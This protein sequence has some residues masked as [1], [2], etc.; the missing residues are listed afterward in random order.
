[1]FAAFE[2]D[3]NVTGT[4]TNS[5]PTEQRIIG[6][7]LFAHDDDLIPFARRSLIARVMQ[8][9]RG[10]QEHVPV[11][12]YEINFGY[13]QHQI[14]TIWIAFDGQL[15]DISSLRVQAISHMESTFAQCILL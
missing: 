11:A 10:I 2:V 5:I 1:M 9:A 14:A 4:G 13:L 3:I 8:L 12:P 6:T 15:H 7:N